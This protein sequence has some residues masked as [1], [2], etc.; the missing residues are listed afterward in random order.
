[1]YF[2]SFVKTVHQRE[3]RVERRVNEV[4]TLET[5]GSML[6]DVGMHRAVFGWRGLTGSNPRSPN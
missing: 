1:V 3:E 2:I 6:G 4:V 5:T